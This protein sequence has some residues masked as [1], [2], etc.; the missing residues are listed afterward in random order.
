M[1]WRYY[2]HQKL[3]KII[4]YINKYKLYFIIQF[5]KIELNLKTNN[6][7]LYS[8]HF[9]LMN[10][11][12]KSVTFEHIGDKKIDVCKFSKKFVAWDVY[13]FESETQINY[14]IIYILW[15]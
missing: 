3:K 1:Y 14:G 4:I 5:Y 10:L 9:I 15:M 7:L 12:L 2:V 13:S 6:I 11:M 8:I